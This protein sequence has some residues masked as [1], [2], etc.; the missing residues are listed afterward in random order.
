MSFRSEVNRLQGESLE[1]RKVLSKWAGRDADPTGTTYYV[2][3]YDG[4]NG[5]DG[6]SW[7]RPFLTM[8]KAFTSVASG[9]TIYFRGKVLEQL[10]AP[11]QVHDVTV[12]GASNRSRHADS[13]PA[14][15]TGK[16]H[17]ASWQPPA[18][19]AATTP[20]VKVLQQGWTFANFLFDA[21]ADAAAVQLH[22]DD[23]S[24][25]AER[26]ASHASFYNVKFA[27]GQS[28]IECTGGQSHVLVDDCEFNALTNGIKGM[29]T[30]VRIP[31]YWDI[32]DSRF[33]NNTNHVITS[34]SFSVI[35][36]N[37]FAKHT[38]DG[39][40]AK[41]NSSQGEYNTV[42][43]NYLSGTYSIS[44]GYT[45]AANDEWAGNFNSLSGGITA[46]DPA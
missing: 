16:S 29:D 34:L 4:I 10:T 43:G 37:T 2:D 12:I 44:G 28:G 33:V 1:L 46:A 27:N 42:W 3:A 21:P 8:A 30:G 15:P 38:T 41:Y 20:C 24:G 39:I 6:K 19:P 13:A 14:D 23:G 25:N 35:K 32:R 18:S 40:Q 5:N 7:E 36:G 26:D 45:P 17:G 22:S 11:V 9:D 31:S